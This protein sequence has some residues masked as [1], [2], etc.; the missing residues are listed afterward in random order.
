MAIARSLILG[1]E[2]LIADEPIAS[3]DVSLQADIIKLIGELVQNNNMATLF[4]SHDLEMLSQVANRIYVLHKGIVVESGPTL[5]VFANPVHPYTRM[6]VSSSRNKGYDR[7]LKNAFVFDARVNYLSHV[8]APRRL[9]PLTDQAHH[10]VYGSP[11]EIA[12]W[13]KGEYNLCNMS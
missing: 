10:L 13:Q 9:L 8:T 11:E 12:L 7:E 5:A 6:L 4:I 3:L 2:L 1:P